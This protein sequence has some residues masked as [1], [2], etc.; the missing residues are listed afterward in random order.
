MSWAKCATA[1]ASTTVC[2]SS[3]ECL[4]ISLNADAAILFKSNSGSCIH[5]TNNG[6]APASTTACESSVGNHDSCY[7]YNYLLFHNIFCLRL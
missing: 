4:Q 2:A 7:Q 3:G 5:K 6:T 1:P